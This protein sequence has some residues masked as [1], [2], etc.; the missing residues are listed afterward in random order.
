[1]LLM[2]VRHV[3]PPNEGRM[4]RY[5]CCLGRW[6][7]CVPCTVSYVRVVR[8]MGPQMLFGAELR[9][10]RC[11]SSRVCGQRFEMTT[12]RA[13]SFGP[14]KPLLL[15]F[16]FVFVFFCLVV[17]LFAFWQVLA[18]KPFLTFF[19]TRYGG[20]LDTVKLLL[21]KGPTEMTSDKLCQYVGFG[22]CSHYALHVLNTTGALICLAVYT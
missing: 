12:E 3:G 11:N 15:I 14:R 10:T 2:Y 5:V 13:P 8:R 6:K 7:D 9:N 17:G 22:F 1:M 16:S 18:R 4:E 21:A 20:S 19:R